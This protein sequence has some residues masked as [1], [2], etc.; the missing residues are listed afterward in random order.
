LATGGSD[1][2]VSRWDALSGE[3][4]GDPMR[5]HRGSVTAIAC[6]STLDGR[7]IMVTGGSDG[8]VRRWDESTGKPVGQP[9][10]GPIRGVSAIVVDA[11]GRRPVL[12]VAGRD[13]TVGRW[14][15]ATGRRAGFRQGLHVYHAVVALA[16][17][18]TPTAGGSGRRW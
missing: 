8:K 13:G 3:P 18:L 6:A 2:R 16:A 7:L 17:Y 12:I 9:L 5:A 10:Q 15:V 14:D 1:G 11:W 4:I